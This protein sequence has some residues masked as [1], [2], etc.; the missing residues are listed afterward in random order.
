MLSFVIACD[1]QHK[2]V[3]V[4]YGGIRLAQLLLQSS[5]FAGY[6]AIYKAVAD[7][8][9]QTAQDAGINLELQLRP[10]A[11][12]LGQGIRYRFLLIRRERQG[13][14]YVSGHRPRPL[15]PLEFLLVQDHHSPRSDAAE[16]LINQAALSSLVE[17]L[18]DDLVGHRDG[19]ARH[20]TS[21]LSQHLLA[22]SLCLGPC[23]GDNALRLGPSLSQDLFPDLFPLPG[24]FGQDLFPLLLRPP[25]ALLILSFG[26][27]SLLA[28]LLSVGQALSYPLLTFLKHLED[29]LPQQEVE[30]SEEDQEVDDLGD[31][32][33]DINTQCP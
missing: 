18:A 22:V 27:L 12:M 5:Q 10:L 15:G 33:R 6:T 13:S 20:L 7:P 28:S 9:H 30:G 29:P 8:D 11:Q 17:G 16:E 31:E 25:D 19:Q 1:G 23:F 3:T 14:D 24:S 32:E 21:E 4:L 2:Q 26:P